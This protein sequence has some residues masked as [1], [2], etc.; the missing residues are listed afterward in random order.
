MS[1]KRPLN[2]W[3][4]TIVLHKEAYP[5][6]RRVTKYYSCL[7]SPQ[8]HMFCVLINIKKNK[9]W[10]FMWSDSL[11]DNYSI[12]ISSHIFFFLFL[13]KSM[14]C[15][16]IIMKIRLDISCEWSAMQMIH[17]KCQVCLS[18]RL[19]TSKINPYLAEHDMPCLNKQCRSRS[20]GF[21]RSQLI[22][23]CTVCH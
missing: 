3:M 12:I 19:M 22:W 21:F 2:K 20:V 11:G 13:D 8:K 14:F 10:H 6:V 15:V 23:I 18:S 16:F 5:D 9:A 7:I 1:V 17:M 4:Q